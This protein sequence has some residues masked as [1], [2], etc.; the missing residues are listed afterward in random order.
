MLREI[1]ATAY[2]KIIKI[3]INL[4]IRSNG[5]LFPVVDRWHREPALSPCGSPEGSG[6]VCSL[7]RAEQ[8]G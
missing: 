3:K 1:T 6:G 7:R 2:S 4:Y 8:G 5:N